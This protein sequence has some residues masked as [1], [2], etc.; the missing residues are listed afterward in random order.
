MAATA[1]GLAIAPAAGA[2]G[3]A[4][5][6]APVGE[7]PTELPL[8]SLSTFRGVKRR[9]EILLQSPQL[10]VIEDF[11]HHPTALAEAMQSFRARFPGIVL[12]V[13]FEPRSNTART[14]ALQP[15][16]M[17]A[18][19][20]AD[21]VYIGA[22]NRADK[23]TPAERFDAEAVAQQLAAQGVDAHFAPTNAALLQTMTDRVLATTQ[24]RLVVFFS[25]GSF[26]GIIGQF[27][28]AARNITG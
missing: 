20:L 12:T 13:A 1:A 26:D 17:R 15:A 5:A 9:Q 24:P 2:S 10:T 4:P 23:L 22:V 16:F 19:G 27:V 7:S 11:G 14:K 18:L 3:N 25:N 8:A 28:N 6:F 21:E